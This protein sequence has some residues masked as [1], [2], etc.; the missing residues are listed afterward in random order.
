MITIISTG[1]LYLA[2]GLTFGGGV[3]LG[4]LLGAEANKNRNVEKRG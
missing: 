1:I 3:F 4:F 2:L